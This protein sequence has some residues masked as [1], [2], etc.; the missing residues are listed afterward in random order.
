MD[1]AIAARCLAALGYSDAR[2]RFRAMGLRPES[3]IDR[4]PAAIAS[5]LLSGRDFTD[6]EVDALWSPRDELGGGS[7]GELIERGQDEQW[8]VI[9]AEFAVRHFAHELARRFLPATLE[10]A[11]RAL[12]SG[13]E[14]PRTALQ[15]I[16]KATSAL[17]FVAFGEG[18]GS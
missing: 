10:T 4:A 17:D 12:R 15:N 1:T 3:F 6:A 9:L 13:N 11:A 2:E 18:K 16:T 5:I 7:W 14:T 8:S